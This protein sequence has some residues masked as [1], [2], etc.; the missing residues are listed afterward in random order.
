MKQQNRINILIA[1]PAYNNQVYTNYVITIFD[2]FN[3]G[4]PFSVTF[5][6][7]ESLITRCRNA[8]ISEFY[9]RT[10]FTH[11]LFLDADVGIEPGGILKLINHVV[12]SNIDVIGARVPIKMLNDKISNEKLTSTFNIEE[13]IKDDLLV[14]EYMAT[15]VFMLSRNA[16]NSLVE[17]AIKNNRT[18][19]ASKINT[20][21][22]KWGDIFDIFRVDIL[23]K[24]YLSEDWFLCN[25]LRELDYK[26]HVDPTIKTS[27]FGTLAF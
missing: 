9:Y 1:T 21:W 22:W 10:E 18:Y 13:K 23:N 12:G 6:G 20:P 27:H 4:I 15:G 19:N 5:L 14:I 8:L 16:V 7:S 11:L 25:K 2:I 24:K 3:S 17:D 26:I